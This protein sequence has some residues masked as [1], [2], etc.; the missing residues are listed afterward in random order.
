VNEAN[1]KWLLAIDTST[2]QAS[3]AFFDGERLA[4]LS[5]PAGRDQTVSVLDQ[6]DHLLTLNRLT[7]SDLAAVAVATGPGM[8]NGLRVGMSVAKGL[9]F[10]ASLP[11]IGVPTLN[12]VV[13]PLFGCGLP[14]IGVLKA[15]RGRLLWSIHTTEST[16]KP[17]NGTVEELVHEANA[18]G[19]ELMVCGEISSAHREALLN[20]AWARVAPLSTVLNRAASVAELAWVRFQG[21]DF[22]DPVTLEPTYLHAASPAGHP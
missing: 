17:K 20:T 13:M 15:G 8:F 14:V 4:N 5:W 2:E 3:I 1:G 22:D 18:H 10:S 16:S 9:A 7:I 12:A 11:L 21:G 6:I 19:S